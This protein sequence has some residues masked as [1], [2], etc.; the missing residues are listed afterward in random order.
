[1]ALVA[2]ASGTRIDCDRCGA[3]VVS[4]TLSATALREELSYVAE[5]D[6]DYCPRCYGETHG[7]PKRIAAWSALASGQ[8]S[9]HSN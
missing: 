6:L 8:E 3:H 4:P 5:A 2:S 1:M 9:R 7:L